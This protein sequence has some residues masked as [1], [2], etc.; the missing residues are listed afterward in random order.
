M[1][2]VALQISRYLPAARR[3]DPRAFAE[4]VRVT[5]STVSAISLAVVRDVQ[6][7][8]DIAQEAYLKVWQKLGD[9][10]NPDSFLP[11][12]RQITRNL[13]RDHL[14]RGKARPGDR[15]GNFDVLE[16]IAAEPEGSAAGLDL[17]RQYD[18]LN[19]A[20]DRLPA[21]G[22]EVIALY[23]REGQSS[24][25]VAH[26]LGL[27]AAAVR[28]RLSRARALLR[29]DVEQR[30]AAVIVASTPGAAFT[31]A[32]TALLATA[33][34]PAAAA[35]AAGIGAK[36]GANFLL[37]A[38]LGILLGL[39][40]G[41]A[42]IVFGIRPWL[43]TSIDP[44]ER[45]ALLRQRSIGIAFVAAA[46]AGL[47]AAAALPGWQV[48]TLVYLAFIGSLFWHTRIALPRI[49][50][51]RLRAERE[52]NPEAARRQYRQ[53]LYGWLGMAAGTLAGGAGLVT[54]LVMTGRL[55]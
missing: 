33:S 48:P 40:G 13:A 3:G 20:F 37:G 28:Q 22:R 53:R 29:T 52:A 12:L 51:A 30:L 32:V 42:G 25:K 1:S 46:C 23:Y 9:L 49:L 14:R 39:L 41:I 45:A 24:D 26:L 6:H 17:E 34:P 10:K 4:L 47:F 35:V 27:S 55:G 8:E 5:Q 44:V 21:T 11:W 50:E 18:A 19:E 38:G 7:A 36:T 15:P 2:E 31:A 54:G 43:K 16:S